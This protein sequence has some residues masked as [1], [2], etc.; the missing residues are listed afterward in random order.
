MHELA[1]E[2]YEKASE[3]DPYDADVY[4]AWGAA[5]KTLG[6]FGDAAEVYRRAAD[7]I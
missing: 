3:L 5:L 1:L 4:D 6:R 2:K 7:Y